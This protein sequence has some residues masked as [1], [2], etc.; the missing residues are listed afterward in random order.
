MVPRKENLKYTTYL[1]FPKIMITY[2]SKGCMLVQYKA[3]YI[4]CVTAL[5][6][7]VK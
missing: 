6:I 5:W 2:M 3:K 7:K 4:K 1:N